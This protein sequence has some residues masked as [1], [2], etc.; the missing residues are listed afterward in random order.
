MEASDEDIQQVM[1]RRVGAMDFPEVREEG[2]A[3]ILTWF[4]GAYNDMISVFFLAARQTMCG[5]KRVV[6]IGPMCGR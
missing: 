4:K 2:A 1:V 6:P 5:G 3:P